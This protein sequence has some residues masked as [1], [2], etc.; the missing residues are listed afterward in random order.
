[1]DGSEVSALID[2]GGAGI[3]VAI[4][5]IGWRIAAAL[6]DLQQTAARW[7]EDQ[8]AHTARAVEHYAATEALLKE[9][10]DDRQGS[11]ARRTEQARDL[12]RMQARL[13]SLE[14]AHA[15]RLRGTLCA[16]GRR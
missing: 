14:E 7:A 16:D 11:D 13:E 12:I 10:R 8:A 15:A 9:I 6:R 5:A 3:G 2:G 1:M 4:A